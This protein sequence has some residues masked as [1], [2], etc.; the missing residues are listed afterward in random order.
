MKI[1]ILGGKLSVSWL[2]TQNDNFGNCFLTY[3]E[4]FALLL[5]VLETFVL[6]M[7]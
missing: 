1:V 3:E 6:P 4:E 5:A 2:A 7:G